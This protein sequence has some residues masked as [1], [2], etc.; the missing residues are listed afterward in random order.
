MYYYRAYFEDPILSDSGLVPETH[1][2]G[3][4]MLLPIVSKA[5]PLRHAGVRV[6]SICNS[7]SFLTSAPDGVSGR[8]H[9]QTALYPLEWIAV[10]HC[11]GGWV[12]LRARLD[13]G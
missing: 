11:A 6:E 10:A 2:R 8:L 5:V 12:G 4:P 9:A 7:Y 3:C 1:F 13:T